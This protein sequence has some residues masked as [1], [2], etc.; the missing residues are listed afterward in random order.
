MTITTVP[1]I[2]PAQTGKP[3]LDI[4]PELQAFAFGPTAAPGSYTRAEFAAHYADRSGRSLDAIEFYYAFGLFKTAVV[5][6]Q[7]YV[8]Y[9]RGHTSD[10]RFA[11]MIEGVRALAAQAERAIASPGL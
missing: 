10:P 2:I 4:V 9:V 8:R 5:A 11:V 1:Q 6:Q 7:I 3:V